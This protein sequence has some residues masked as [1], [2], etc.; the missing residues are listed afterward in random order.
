MALPALHWRL[1]PPQSF[2]SQNSV[3]AA[4]DAIYAAGTSTTYADGSPRVPGAFAAPG[5]ASLPSSLGTGSA[6]TWNYD[7]TSMSISGEKTAC[8]AYPPTTTAINQS[9]IIAGVTGTSPPLPA[10]NWKTIVADTRSQNLLY[11]GTSKNGGVYTTW[12]NGTTPFTGGDF[13]GFGPCTAS[14]STTAYGLLLM[15]ECEEA[16]SIQIVRRTTTNTGGGIAGAYIDPLSVNPLNA[17]SDGRLYGVSTAGTAALGITGPI[18]TTTGTANPIY[19]GGAAN[20]AHFVCF[21]PGAGTTLPLIRFGDYTG[22]S[23]N[24]TN[25]SGDLPQI[26]VQ[27]ATGNTYIGQFRQIFATRNSV[28]GLTWR[29]GATAKGYLWSATT[30]GANETLLLTV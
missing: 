14:F 16:I 1:L 26:P 4:L 28:T 7:N 5:T 10:F 29:D 13:T 11:M 6:W 15:W 12:N 30:G 20:N 3:A 8:Y 18:L 24:F 9:V 27:I 19:H 17:E 23:V 21:T 22:I 2:V 25:T